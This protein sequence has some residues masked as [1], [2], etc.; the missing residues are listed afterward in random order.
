[1][2]TDNTQRRTRYENFIADAIV[3]FKEKVKNEYP[4]TS[5]TEAL[6]AALENPDS[7]AYKQVIQKAIQAKV[8]EI[9]RKSERTL[10]ETQ[11]LDV[12][13]NPP[14]IEASEPAAHDEQHT[15]Q[16]TP[17]VD[18]G[19]PAAHD[20]QHTDQETPTPA[21][22]HAPTDEQTAPI[23][24]KVTTPKRLASDQIP[25][26]VMLQVLEQI[27]C[28]YTRID[29]ARQLLNQED[30]PDWLLP[31]KDMEKREAANLLSQRFRQADPGSK[32]FAATKYQDHLEKAQELVQQHLKTRLEELITNAID[33]YQQ[34]QTDLDKLITDVKADMEK[35]NTDPTEK[36][37]MIKLCSKLMKQRDD[38][39]IDFLS[40]LKTIL[41]A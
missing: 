16:E 35:H 11:L 28:G 33:T 8:F 21:E 6:L 25:Q 34:G 36:R 4:G 7:D 3:H 5:E 26:E 18:S 27:V 39:E 17:L 41:H 10:E 19:E 29:I 20:E 9:R 22:E 38:R 13:E 40:Q 1:M 12:L 15:D 2:N 14:I 24:Q 23:Q 37:Q 30:M 31:L 32:K